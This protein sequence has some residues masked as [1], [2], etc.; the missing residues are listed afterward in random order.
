MNQSD[1]RVSSLNCTGHSAIATALHLG[2][3]VR[4]L[5]TQHDGVLLVEDAGGQDGEDAGEH[6][7]EFG[8]RLL[9]LFH[10]HALWFCFIQ[11]S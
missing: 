5:D 10:L 7:L 8:R 1:R 2:D 11:P 9:L 3:P 6:R 4:D